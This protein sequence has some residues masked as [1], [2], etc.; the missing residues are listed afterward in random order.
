[1]KKFATVVSLSPSCSAIVFCISL[2]GRFVCWK[3]ANSVRRW[4]SV[5]TK[6]G[7]F[8]GMATYC[9]RTL[10]SKSFRLQAEIQNSWSYNYFYL[11]IFIHSSHMEEDDKV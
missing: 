7:F 2:F 9:W 10:V 5:K 6:R 8:V 11:F 3:I 1:M 4:I